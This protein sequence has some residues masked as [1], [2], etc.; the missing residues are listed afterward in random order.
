MK[1]DR[2]YRVEFE[3]RWKGEGDWERDVRHVLANG[4]AEKAIAATRKEQL[5]MTFDDDDTGKRVP[6]VGFR[7][8][9]VNVV[10]TADIEA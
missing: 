5:A 10:A 4:S 9:A 7:L 3:R 8:L 1:R 6:V 2:I